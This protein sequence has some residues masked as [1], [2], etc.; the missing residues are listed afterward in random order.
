LHV[1]N[2]VETK[3]F[4]DSLPHKLDQGCDDLF[5][6]VPLDEME[7]G[8]RVGSTHIGHLPSADAVRVGD[9]PAARRLPEHFCEAHGRNDAAFDQVM[10]HRARPPD[11]S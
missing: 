9:D 10:E 8:T 6:L 5:R 3:P 2:R 7:V 4:W 11:G 1:A